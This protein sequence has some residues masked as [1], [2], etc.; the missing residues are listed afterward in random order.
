MVYLIDG[1]RVPLKTWKSRKIWGEWPGAYFSCYT[2]PPKL[3]RRDS[4]GR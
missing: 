3:E 2:P 4:R 1:V